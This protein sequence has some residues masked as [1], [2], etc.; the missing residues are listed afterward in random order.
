MAA[1]NSTTR[2]TGRG[3]FLNGPPWPQGGERI[4]VYDYY[5]DPHTDYTVR[6]RIYPGDL[7]VVEANGEDVNESL[8]MALA[9]EAAARKLRGADHG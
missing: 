9:L 6:I 3:N 7:V 1:D 5:T 2:P 4:T 8:P